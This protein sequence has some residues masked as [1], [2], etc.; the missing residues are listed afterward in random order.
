[1][2]KRYWQF[3]KSGLSLLLMGLLLWAC[4][5]NPSA[6]QEE[7]KPEPKTPE[8]LAW[9]QAEGDDVKEVALPL[10]EQMDVLISSIEEYQQQAFASEQTKL[11]STESLIG[12]IEQSMTDY[13]RSQ[14][15]S[16]KQSLAAMLSGLYTDETMTDLDLMTA[17]DEHTMEVVEGCHGAPTDKERRVDVGP[18]PLKNFDQLRPIAHLLK[19]NHPQRC[20]GDQKSIKRFCTDFR[21]SPIERLEVRLRRRL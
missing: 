1:M 20:T 13:N 9:E 11:N 17:Y 8:D 2:Q 5:S 21:P 12:E 4:G 3:Y 6:N 10:N 19:G 15:D 14:L 7:E 16:I 18:R